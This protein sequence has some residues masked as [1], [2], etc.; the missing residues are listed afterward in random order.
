MAEVLD[1]KIY[2]NG[3][4]LDD[5]ITA[6]S[7]AE[8]IEKANGNSFFLGQSVH[9]PE[10]FYSVNEIPYP[11]DF[12]SVP[13]GEDIKWEF[14]TTPTIASLEDFENF[15]DFIDDFHKEASYYPIS[16]GAKVLVDGEEF[17]FS[18][19][20]DGQISWISTQDIFDET[21]ADAV[22]L[23]VDE[24]TS[25]A[26]EAFDTLKEIEDWIKE[27]S[28]NTGTTDISGLATK[29]ELA[30]VESKIPSLDGYAKIEDLEGIRAEIPSVDGFV[31]K[32]ELAE[33]ESKIPSME[34]VATESWVNEQ[35]FLTE[36]Q[37]I[38]H[39]ATSA[40]VKTAI[41]EVESKIPSLDGYATETWVKNEIANAQLSGETEI[42]TYTSGTGISIVDNKINVLVETGDTENKNYLKVNEDN[43]LSVEEIG[44]DDTVTTEDIQVN[45]GAWASDI[46]EIYGDTIPVGTSFQDFLKAM[47]CKE[48]FINDVTIVSSF[49]VNCG[50]IDP[51]IDAS[52]TVEVGTKVTLN[53]TVANDT[54]ARQAL[55]AKTFT[56]GYKLGENG[57]HT[58]STEY[59][60][61][62]NLTKD[63]TSQTSL[64]ITFTRF[65]DA[66]NDG[67]VLETVSGN[68]S[69]D[70][71][72]MYAME[73]INKVTVYQT[74]DTYTSSSAMTG[75][76]IY[77]ATN[78]KNYY[79]SDKV[80]PNTYTPSF[81]V[82]SKTATDS[83]EYSVTGAHK[84]YIGDITDYD[85][86]YWLVNRS[87]VVRGLATSGWATNKII[88][89][90]HTFKVGTK[91][92]TVVVPEVYK[93][94]VG[95]DVNNGEVT[96][97]YVTTFDFINGQGFVSSY[98]VFV[99]P[100]LD[101][102]GTDSLINI[103][104]S[105]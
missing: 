44:L 83:T 5:N 12:W 42:V 84:Y 91:Q 32:E 72:E 51:G 54:T 41:E 50:N 7:I 29:E 103:T 26:S 71:I 39:L 23:A 4:Y 22:K 73:G 34:G 68:T 17:E 19:T 38:S 3:G 101:G 56:Y 88:T 27:I 21:I 62:W 93:N 28:G 18:I 59:V 48:Y 13:N 60:E 98:N 14:K 16:K 8:L 15:K 43:S 37:D 52:G 85:A 104:M 64:K 75:G 10:A 24:V 31:T 1:S 61:K 86:D 49:T 102:L 57:T 9:M 81:P 35:G 2:V 53:K 79:K 89:T 95:K 97:N 25:G 45:G 76:T 82:T 99:A 46:K 30:E 94:V 69:I 40:N 70:A 36:H 96:F 6:L 80:T 47:S 66:L 92:Q 90:P 63:E 78:L 87:S 20:E 55:T 105:K 77:I 65:V 67:T 58:N 100:A 11:I 33:V 74:G